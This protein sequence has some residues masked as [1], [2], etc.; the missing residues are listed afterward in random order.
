VL[1]N[2]YKEINVIHHINKLKD[3]N[4]M[5]IS[6]DTEKVFDKSNSLHDKS[7]GRLGIQGSQLNIV[8]TVYNK[9]ITNIN[10]RGDKLKAIL[11]K[12]GQDKIAHCLHTY[13]I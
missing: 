5:T 2:I 4:H 13:S 8:K 6:L 11:M 10:L 9:P 1:F 12:S 7:P 3:K